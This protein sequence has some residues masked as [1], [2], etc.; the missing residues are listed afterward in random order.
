MPCGS[1]GAW[2]GNRRSSLLGGLG[3]GRSVVAGP[4]RVLLVVPAQDN[5]AVTID[6]RAQA[7]AGDGVTAGRRAHPVRHGPGRT[8]WTERLEPEV[9]GLTGLT[10]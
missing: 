1:H 3:W 2:T 6:A 7:A 9:V 10:T 5:L 4:A 8:A